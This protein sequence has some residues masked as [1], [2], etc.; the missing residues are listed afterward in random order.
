MY[1]PRYDDTFWP[2]G[3]ICPVSSLP[4]PFLITRIEVNDA[5]R[6]NTCRKS[7][8]FDGSKTKETHDISPHPKHTRFKMHFFSSGNSLW[9]CKL[10]E[11]QKAIFTTW[12]VYNPQSSHAPPRRDR[13]GQNACVDMPLAG[14]CRS[15]LSREQW[16]LVVYDVLSCSRSLKNY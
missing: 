3:K 9:I 16:Q 8:V 11:H 7:C 13:G 12:L 1:A 6:A 5:R 4:R 10:Q 15:A 2:K 14:V